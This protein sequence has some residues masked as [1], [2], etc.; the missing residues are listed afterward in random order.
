MENQELQALFNKYLERKASAE[1]VKLLLDHFQ[2][3]HE[4]EQLKA[5][6]FLE[7]EKPLSDDNII[8]INEGSIYSR[9][10]KALAERIDREEN[11]KSYFWP[12]RIAASVAAVL[13][14]IGGYVLW[15]NSRPV[16]MKTAYAAYGKI[17]QVQLPDSSKVWLNAGTTI[18][19]PEDF[20]GSTRTVSIKNG[21]AFFDVIHD[22]HK[23]FVVKTRNTEVTVLGTSFE[24]SAYEQEKDA[25]IVVSTGKVGLQLN[26]HKQPAT[27]LTPGEQAI[28]S[29]SDQ[30]VRVTKLAL[31]DIAVWRQ[32]KLIFEDQP[33]E[34]VLQSLERK[35]NVQIRIDNKKL[36][37]EKVSMR[38][39][40]QP[41]T[42]VLTAI[43][44]ANHFNYEKI[45]DQLI[46]VK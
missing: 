43:S 9:V 17:L 41:L 32:Q 39:N 6:I 44:F 2:L 5:L 3:E 19:Y 4:T 1:E 35:Y 25:K 33:L 22:A 24:V 23:P 40:N 31:S 8:R 28:I 30:A 13:I 10:E 26:N 7:L 14:L 34:E 42:D 11:K 15:D 16:I 18:A 21:D 27:F 45:N 29:N 46:V 37:T 38:L 36:L 20:K 12:V